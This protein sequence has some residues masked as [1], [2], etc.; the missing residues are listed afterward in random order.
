M[1]W[2]D[3]EVDAAIARAST[4]F[5]ALEELATASEPLPG[6]PRELGAFLARLPEAVRAWRSPS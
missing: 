6:D 4:V 2:G 5:D 3:P 1:T